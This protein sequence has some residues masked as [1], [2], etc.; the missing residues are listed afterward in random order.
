MQ[1]R[2]QRRSE[3]KVKDLVVAVIV[4]GSSGQRSF[5]L[6]RRP[7]RKPITASV[8]ACWLNSHLPGADCP[9]R[10]CAGESVG[11]WPGRGAPGKP[12]GA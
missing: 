6:A 1:F 4:A 11:A 10:R 3:V 5:C 8:Y 12:S 7:A 9:G 2:G